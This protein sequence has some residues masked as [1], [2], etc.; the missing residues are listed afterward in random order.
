MVIVKKYNCVKFLLFY[1]LGFFNEIYLF[2][3]KILAA[4]LKFYKLLI[5]FS[6]AKKLQEFKNF[7]LQ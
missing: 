3:Y 2:Y 5:N 7:R 1:V 6:N 4:Y